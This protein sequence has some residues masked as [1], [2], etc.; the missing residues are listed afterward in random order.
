MSLPSSAYPPIKPYATEFLEVGD[1]H[2]LYVEQVGNPQGLPVLF[3]HG[4]PGGG[5]SP[6]HRQ[7]FNPEQFRVILFDQRGAG[8]ST[9]HA[10]LHANTT[11]YLVADIERIR[12]HLGIERWA[13]LGGSWGSTLAL[14]Y[15]QTHPQRVLHL[16]LRGIFLCRPE[17]IEWFYQQ[18]CHW[19]SP[20]QW[21]AYAGWLS[22]EEQADLVLAYYKRLC[23]E[24]EAVR[25]EAA[26]R[27]A[28][29]EGSNLKLLPDETTRADFTADAHALALARIEC[30]YFINQAFFTAENALLAKAH[31]LANIPIDLI[32]GRYDL[33]CPLKNA[34]DLHQAVP[35]SVLTVVPDAGHAF[36][37]PGIFKAQQAAL[38]KLTNK[39]L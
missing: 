34:W 15:A 18:G 27:W 26:K 33:V 37:E 6:K 11:W 7:L 25:L 12:I 30:H 35:H 39:L 4:G 32:H 17:E 3:L 19:L 21:Q 8:K 36:D 13:V 38:A 29:W 22:A 10:S 23:S 1:G 16:I 28:D 24:D 14:A 2:T 9:P 31:A 5:I 20:Q